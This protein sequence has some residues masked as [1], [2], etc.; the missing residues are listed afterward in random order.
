ME[1]P[2]DARTAEIDLG[3]SATFPGA[4]ETSLEAGPVALAFLALTV[5]LY[6]RPLESPVTL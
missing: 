3:A 6:V 2:F 1:M 4:A 5:I